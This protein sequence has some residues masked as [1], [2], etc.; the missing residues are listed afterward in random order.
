VRIGIVIPAFN[1]GR[2]IGAAIAS[3]LAQSHTG[4]SLV[5]VDDGSTDHT[6]DVVAGFDDRR[7]RLIR[8]ANAGVSVAR[9]RGIAELA[10][11]F[12]CS[13]PPVGK[14]R[15]G[16]LFLDADD[17]LASDALC[18]L[19]A[20]LDAAPAAVAA[21]GPCSFAD[22]GMVR[23]PP[24][25]DLLRRLLV[26][27]LFANGGHVLLR[28]EAVH[29]AGGFLPG[30]AYGEDWEFWIRIALQGRFVGVTGNA[31]VLFLRRHGE[32]AYRR[33]AAEAAAFGPCM[34]AIFANPAL[35]ARFGAKRLAAIRRQTEAENDW[36]VGREQIRHG[37]GASGLRRLR[38]SVRRHLTPR[39]AVLLA[40][41]HAMPLLPTAWRGRLR[42]YRA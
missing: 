20:A 11:T 23:S 25:G 16:M 33:L 32:G 14:D 13:R 28:A 19:A 1:A 15:V 37:C 34:D 2:W 29:A 39:R 4:W 22:T 27:N 31:P 7:I 21:S 12:P 40:A 26:R 42:P 17:S 8:Q 9:N 24:S 36:I 38:R 6:G 30:V 5:V 35:L 41:A 10:G 3:V 18:R